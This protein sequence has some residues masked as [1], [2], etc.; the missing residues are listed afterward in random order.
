MVCYFFQTTVITDIAVYT[1][2]KLRGVVRLGNTEKYRNNGKMNREKIRRHRGE[3]FT[4][5]E[6]QIK[7]PYMRQNSRNWKSVG[8]QFK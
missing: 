5:T 1:D 6:S 8:N 3:S 4:G 2:N 7:S